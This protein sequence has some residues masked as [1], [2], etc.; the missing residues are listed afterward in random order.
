MAATSSDK[1]DSFYRI[2]V[3]SRNKLCSCNRIAEKGVSC[4]KC[5]KKYHY[6]C[7]NTTNTTKS[8]KCS[9][10]L[11]SECDVAEIKTDPLK[12]C[13]CETLKKELRMVKKEL[14]CSKTIISLLTN[15]LQKREAVNKELC[16]NEKFEV[17]SINYDSE[18]SVHTR[19]QNTL[20]KE[21]QFADASREKQ[22]NVPKRQP[23]I[24]KPKILITADSHGRDCA[25][26]I[27]NL[28]SDKYEIEGKVMPGAPT[29][30]I[31]QNCD[32]K[33]LTNEDYA[34]IWAGANDVAK[35]EAN[36]A[37]HCLQNALSTLQNT[38]VI[39]TGVPH[40]H[41][42]P[43]WSCVNKE[44][45]FTNRKLTKIVKGFHNAC[46]INT[47]SDKDLYTAHGLHLNATGKEVMAKSILN[48]VKTNREVYK[49]AIALKWKDTAAD[50]ESVKTDTQ[51]NVMQKTTESSKM[52]HVSETSTIT[53][54]QIIP[55]R[56][57]QKLGGSNYVAGKKTSYKKEDQVT[58]RRRRSNY[59]QA[60]KKPTGGIRRSTRRRNP[61]PRDQDFWW[62]Q[63]MSHREKQFK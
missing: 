49:M 27:L 50:K 11:R 17:S 46:F 57:V 58:Q 1:L 41:D 5:K 13:L 21:K 55:K 38:N 3:E 16:K 61:L 8:W 9:D 14:K 52:N 28:A 10:C 22:S 63:Q 33:K 24:R 34:V 20:L 40:R 2:N 45:Q 15:E 53:Q 29:S 18:L 54:G 44:I 7:V 59:T 32:L 19:T 23:H 6:S 39:V 4:A 35:N 31:L 48:S 51:T 36:M 43:E 60:V 26:N 25:R 37:I 56:A 12:S 30:V 42:L 47:P 62:D